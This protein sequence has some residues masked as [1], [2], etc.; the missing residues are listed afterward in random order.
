MREPRERIHD[1]LEAIAGIERHTDGGREAFD[2]DE[3]VQV[4]VVHQLQIAGEAAYQLPK[5]VHRRHP[6]VPW[7]KIVG[8]R[9]ILVHGYF[10]LDLDIVWSVVEKDLRGLKAQLEAILAEMGDGT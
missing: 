2:A 8:M 1:M 6:E 4:Y 9:H 5:D 10:R 3:L 7:S